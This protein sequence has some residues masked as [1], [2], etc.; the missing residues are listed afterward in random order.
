MGALQFDANQVEPRKAFEPLP[1]GKYLA[2]IT[3]SAWKDTKDKRGKFLELKL[4]VIEGPHKGRMLWD[5]LNLQNHNKQAVDIARATLS[6]ICRAVGIMTPK[7]SIELHNLPLVAKV[8]V[9][10]NEQN[11]D[12]TNVVKAYEKKGVAAPVPA[13]AGAGGKP[14]WER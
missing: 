1:D 13:T 2:V 9:K 8:A 7:D 6:A 12:F 11:G 5:R 14:P 3:E 4:Q 10:K